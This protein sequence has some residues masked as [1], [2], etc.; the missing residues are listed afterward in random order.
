MGHEPRM[1][2]E[3][4]CVGEPWTEQSDPANYLKLLRLVA[5][6]Q[7]P[8]APTLWHFKYTVSGRRTDFLR[9]RLSLGIGTDVFA[10]LLNQQS[11]G[12][13][14]IAII[15]RTWDPYVAFLET[16]AALS[17][18]HV[19][20]LLVVWRLWSQGLAGVAA[21]HESKRSDLATALGVVR[22]LAPAYFN[23]GPLSGFADHAERVGWPKDTLK[24]IDSLA[25]QA[26]IFTSGSPARRAGAHLLANSLN[27][28]YWPRDN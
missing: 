2:T 4:Q 11:S 22:D 28:A 21:T 12:L 26:G 5:R 7:A 1:W 6:V 19:D 25:R 14:L 9:V 20:A 23:G 16:D 15:P 27:L 17:R 24:M 10:E 13:D 3:F 8:L 18:D